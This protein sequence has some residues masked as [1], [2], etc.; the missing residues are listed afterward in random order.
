MTF[1][2]YAG[3][4]KNLRNTVYFYINTQIYFY[5]TKEKILT[6]YRIESLSRNLW[7]RKNNNFCFFL[8]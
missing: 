3:M 2:Q 1:L 5:K 8:I 6:F 7:R 4:F